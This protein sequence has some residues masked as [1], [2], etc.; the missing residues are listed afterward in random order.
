MSQSSIYV[1]FV[2]ILFI[3]TFHT[4]FKLKLKLKLKSNA[5]ALRVWCAFHLRC[6]D[7]DVVHWKFSN[8]H[9]PLSDCFRLFIHSFVRSVFDDNN[10]IQWHSISY[11]DWQTLFLQAMRDVLC[12]NVDQSIMLKKNM[13]CT[14]LAWFRYQP[15]EK[16]IDLVSTRNW[17][18]EIETTEIDTLARTHTIHSTHSHSFILMALRI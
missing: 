17:W 4:N 15:R 7:Y 2:W 14:G 16:E 6:Y 3:S 8:N 18:K 12:T 11:C 13:A 1:L 9:K 10:S 5:I